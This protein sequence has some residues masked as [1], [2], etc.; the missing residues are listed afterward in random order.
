M[1]ISHREP[2]VVVHVLYSITSCSSRAHNPTHAYRSVELKIGRTQ[3]ADNLA[4]ASSRRICVIVANDETAAAIPTRDLLAILWRLRPAEIHG[5]TGGRFP[6]EPN[7]SVFL[8]LFP[9]FLAEAAGRDRIS[10][11]HNEGPR[12][13]VCRTFHNIVRC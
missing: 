13:T 12:G 5:V 2:E 11:C 3:K 6:N 1:C 4:L 7:A 10:R 9:N 8:Y